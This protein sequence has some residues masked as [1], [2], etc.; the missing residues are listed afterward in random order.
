[1]G[2]RWERLTPEERE[3]FRQSLRSRCGDFGGRSEE[4]KEPA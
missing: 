3:K 4:S 2:E 1:M